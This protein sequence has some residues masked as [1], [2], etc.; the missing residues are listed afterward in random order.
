MHYLKEFIVVLSFLLVAHFAT[1]QSNYK[2]GV[3]LRLGPSYGFTIK[4]FISDKVALEGLVTSRYYGLGG[5]ASR[6]SWNNNPGAMFTGL[7]EW[8]FPIG[9]V[10][11][12]NWF[13]GGGFH[14]GVL[15]GYNSHSIFGEDRPYILT[16]FDFVGGVEYT[17]P[18]APFTFQ[19]DVKPS[20][21]LI[22]YVGI[23]YDDIAVSVRYTF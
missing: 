21:H 6:G 23:W 7:A 8:H 3:G 9:N 20:V 16:G 10:Q 5:G 22:E 14:L 1:A 4:H 13:I 18:N 11:G 19:A 2:T 17:L 12:F 15:G